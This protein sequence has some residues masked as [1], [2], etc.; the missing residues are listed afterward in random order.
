MSIVT[1]FTDS[2][3]GWKKKK[4]TKTYINILFDT[5]VLWK[6]VKLENCFFDASGQIWNLISLLC[7]LFICISQAA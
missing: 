5:I 6:T 1:V 2:F 4:N 7:S 3:H